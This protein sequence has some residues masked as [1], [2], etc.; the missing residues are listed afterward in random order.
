MPEESG[1]DHELF[2]TCSQS[3]KDMERIIYIWVRLVPDGGCRREQGSC[4]SLRACGHI[5]H[6]L[7]IAEEASVDKREIMDN[8]LQQRDGWRER[9]RKDR[10]IEIVILI[11]L[12]RKGGCIDDWTLEP[13]SPICV[14]AK[15]H[16]NL[17]KQTIRPDY[18][19]IGPINFSSSNVEFSQALRV[20][21]KLCL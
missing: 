9:E 5:W 12:M 16:K 1:H 3:D 13:R 11:D 14:F 7:F 2:L 4:E 17:R 20:R 19:L 6:K 10:K 18:F 15:A 21:F 8:S